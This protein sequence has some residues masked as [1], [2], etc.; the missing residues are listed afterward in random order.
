MALA[1]S[2]VYDKTVPLFFIK[3]EVGYH[4]GDKQALVSLCI[5]AVLQPLYLRIN[6]RP[7]ILSLEPLRDLGGSSVAK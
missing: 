6:V 2:G 1:I 4:Q 7:L 3:T 5:L